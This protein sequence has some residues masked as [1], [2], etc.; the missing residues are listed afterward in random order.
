M[1]LLPQTKH[2][3]A[4]RSLEALKVVEEWQQEE[5]ELVKAQVYL[6][7]GQQCFSAAHTLRGLA[8]IWVALM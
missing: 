5:C 1:G 3:N 6:S 7:A 8:T 2:S 4:A